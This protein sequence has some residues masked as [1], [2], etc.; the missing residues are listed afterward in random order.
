MNLVFERVIES[1]ENYIQALHWL[2]EGALCI[3]YIYICETAIYL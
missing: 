3:V 2:N 1:E